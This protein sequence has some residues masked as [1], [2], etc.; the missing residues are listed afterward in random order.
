MRLRFQCARREN[1]ADS[2]QT[3]SPL[4]AAKKLTCHG[5]RIAQAM[6]GDAVRLDQTGEDQISI[7]D[8]NSRGSR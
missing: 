3:Q 4:V 1:H 8:P 6:Q 2:V 5:D 7:T